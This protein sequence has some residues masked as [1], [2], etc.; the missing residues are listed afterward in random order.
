VTVEVPALTDVT[1]PLFDTVATPVFDDTH[2]LTAAAVPEPVNCVVLPIHTL[3]VPVIVGSAFTVTVAVLVQPLASLYV[4]VEVPAATAVTNPVDDVVATDVFDD[5]HGV[6]AS[7]VPDPLN[8]VVNP[9]HTASVPLIV[10]SALTVTGV[11][12]WQPLLLV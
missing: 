7:G 1:K 10:G 9:V 12:I 8:C 5:A 11:V 2:G 6:V 3:S 4:T